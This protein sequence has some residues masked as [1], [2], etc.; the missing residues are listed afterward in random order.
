MHF[1]LQ[2]DLEYDIQMMESHR[3]FFFEIIEDSIL[4]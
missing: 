3:V 4:N 1:F 2:D